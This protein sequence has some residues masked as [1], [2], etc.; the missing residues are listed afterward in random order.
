MRADGRSNEVHN[1]AEGCGLRDAADVLADAML[2]AGCDA[3]LH[4]DSNVTLAAAILN[5]GLRLVHVLDAAGA[6]A[7]PLTP[8]RPPSS[9][10]R[11]L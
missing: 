11:I 7:E 10:R 6:R 5:P 1:F 2:L 4:A 3:L 9:A 8:A